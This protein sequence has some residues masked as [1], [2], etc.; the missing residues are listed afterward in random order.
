MQR[1]ILLIISL[2]V[3][4]SFST[5]INAQSKLPSDA[6]FNGFKGKVK[7]VK[8][9][10]IETIKLFLLIPIER[11]TVRFD[12]YFNKDGNMIKFNSFDDGEIKEITLCKFDD[13]NNK[14]LAISYSEDGNNDTILKNIF[15]EDGFLIERFMKTPITGKSKIT[16]KNNEKGLLDS[17]Y[18]VTYN[19]NNED[20][21]SLVEIF[22]YDNNG[23]H[24]ETNKYTDDNK[25]LE[26]I[27]YEFDDEGN[28]IK[29]ETYNKDLILIRATKYKYNDN[30][31]RIEDTFIIYRNGN[32]SIDKHTY[33]YKYDSNGNWIKRKRYN[34]EGS[35]DYIVKRKIEYYKD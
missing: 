26:R 4:T 19:E 7:Y 32:G 34:I 9:M 5:T 27:T 35:I 30:Q 1:K 13:R 15:D 29:F 21:T 17:K 6:S 14:I 20:S 31:D 10:G 33:K 18:I 28:L 23:R 11:E 24:Y 16:Y 3:F 22:L 12:Y 2:F 25:L 8:E